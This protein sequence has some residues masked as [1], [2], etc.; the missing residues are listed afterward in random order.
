MKS[1]K[2]FVWFEEEDSIIVSVEDDV[3]RPNNMDCDAVLQEYIHENYS[4][5][6]YEYFE[7]EA[8]EHVEI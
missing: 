4:S 7:I 2:Y 8:C 3:N 5:E 1:R 6:K